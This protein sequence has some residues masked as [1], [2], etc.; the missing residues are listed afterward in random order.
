[1]MPVPSSIPIKIKTLCALKNKKLFEDSERWNI[2]VCNWNDMPL[3]R[4]FTPSVK[5]K[6]I[7]VISNSIVPDL[8]SLQYMPKKCPL[9]S[10]IRLSWD[11]VTDHWLFS[12]ILPHCISNTA[13]DSLNDSQE[14]IIL[15]VSQWWGCLKQD[16]ATHLHL[17]ILPQRSVN[18]SRQAFIWFLKQRSSE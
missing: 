14:Y 6:N 12:I 10:W 11:L 8:F 5:V 4:I 1:M 17:T 15:D 3:H 18:Q 7:I 13:S 2:T 9:F 16:V